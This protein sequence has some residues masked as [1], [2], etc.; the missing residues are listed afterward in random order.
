[1]KNSKKFGFPRTKIEK[2]MAKQMILELMQSTGNECD[3]RE[4]KHRDDGTGGEND[5]NDMEMENS[6]GRLESKTSSVLE[7]TSKNRRM[8]VTTTTKTG[9]FAMNTVSSTIY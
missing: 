7:D 5:I 3:S 2:D 4:T 6:I 9:K 8:T 1:M